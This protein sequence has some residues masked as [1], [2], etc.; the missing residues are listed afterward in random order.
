MN[1]GQ[2]VRQLRQAKGMTLRALAPQVGVGFTYLS[3]VETGKL[4]YGNFPSEALIR[5]LAEALDADLDE[6]LVLAMIVPDR[7]RSRVMERP[8]V[9]GA[10]ARCDDTTLDRVMTQIRRR[11]SVSK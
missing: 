4:D 9:F 10:L 5:K 1:F 7:I 8:E 6:L 11:G 2:R 3:K